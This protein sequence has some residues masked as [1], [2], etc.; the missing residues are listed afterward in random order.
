MANARF[1]AVFDVDGFQVDGTPAASTPTGVKDADQFGGRQ[2]WVALTGPT[3]TGV[4][5][6]PARLASSAAG[7][8]TVGP[9]A[10]TATAHV[11]LYDAADLPNADGRPHPLPDTS[12]LL[13]A[14]DVAAAGTVRV[15]VNPVVAADP[16]GRAAMAAAF[17]EVTVVRH[18]GGDVSVGGRIV[19]LPRRVVCRVSVSEA[20]DPLG[21]DGIKQDVGTVLARSPGD[22]GP[23]AVSGHWAWLT[24]ATRAD[25][26]LTPDLAEAADGTDPTPIWGEPIVIR[27]VPVRRE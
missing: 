18:C 4:D 10:V 22:G 26:T 5:G 7:P 16:A 8:L 13:A 6:W 15:G 23:F 3:A 27:D 21:D 1:R 25:V 9:H 11:L 14:F 20:N 24:D 17:R 2:V 19:A 12:K